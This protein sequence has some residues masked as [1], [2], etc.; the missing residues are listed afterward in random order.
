MREQLKQ[1][2]TLLFAGT[3]GAEDIRDEIL[4]NT[5]EH[6]DDLLAQGKTPEAAYRLAISGIGDINEILGREPEPVYSREIKKGGPRT[7]RAVAIGLYIVSPTPL[8]ALDSIGQ[9]ILGLCMTILLVAAATVLLLMNKEPH[10]SQPPKPSNPLF[11]AIRLLGVVV[12]LVLSFATHAW[13][14][15]WLVFPI[16]SCVI[17]LVQACFDFTEVER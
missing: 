1:Y 5:L 6:Y 2:V 13:Y 12:Y 16:T 10:E 17:H 4:Q 15:T 9:D 14:I 11:S 8:I 3:V 7:V